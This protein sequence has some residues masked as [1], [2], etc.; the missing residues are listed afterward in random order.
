MGQHGTTWDNMGQHGTTWDNMGQHGTTWEVQG[1]LTV[2]GV[3]A[4][5]HGK[6]LSLLLFLRGRGLVPSERGV[7]GL[8]HCARRMFG[9][10]A[11]CPW[12]DVLGVY[13][14]VPVGVPLSSCHVLFSFPSFP[15]FASFPP[16]LLVL[17]IQPFPSPH[18][19][20]LS[21]VVHHDFLVRQQ[22]VVPRQ[23]FFAFQPNFHVHVAQPP[24]QIVRVTVFKPGVQ[25]QI[26]VHGPT[27]QRQPVFP[28]R[29]VALNVHG[30]QHCAVNKS[31]Q[32]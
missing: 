31:E 17:P 21:S 3:E 29:V 5:L 14:R 2:G 18:L 12:T 24:V 22:S 25:I 6:V 4:V 27:Q 23:E 26:G 30:R 10:T 1:G 15:S 32:K 19:Q 13:L 8:R 28:H 16:S 11:Q 7:R 20:Q 9:A